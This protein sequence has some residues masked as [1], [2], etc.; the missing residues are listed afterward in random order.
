MKIIFQQ[1]PKCKF[2]YIC[3]SNRSN[4]SGGSELRYVPNKN[5]K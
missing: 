5:L 2:S 1:I 4:K 3:T